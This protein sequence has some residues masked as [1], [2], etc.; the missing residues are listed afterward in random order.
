MSTLG[1]IVAKCIAAVEVPGYAIKVHKAVEIGVPMILA[2]PEVNE[3]AAREFLTIKVKASISGTARKVMDAPSGFVRAWRRDENSEADI[4][5][6]VP[7]QGD[8]FID[9]FKLKDGY[10]LEGGIAE[11]KRTRYF[12]QP[13]FRGLLR[14]RRKQLIADGKHYDR[15]AS[16]DKR[17]AEFWDNDPMMTY[18]EACQL[19]VRA[20]GAPDLPDDDEGDD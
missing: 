10:S 1:N 14:I 17:L 19:Y 5:V 8:L 6:I 20:Y 2:D 13:E 11:M 12:T 15:I 16:T 9:P 3:M 7:R 4:E 18:E